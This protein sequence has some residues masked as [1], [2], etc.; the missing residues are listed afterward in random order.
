MEVFWLSAPN[1]KD[2]PD[3]IDSPEAWTGLMLN[4]FCPRVHKTV[5][6]FVQKW[7]QFG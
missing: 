5:A 4:V 1:L 6:S 3:K 7:A 2:I